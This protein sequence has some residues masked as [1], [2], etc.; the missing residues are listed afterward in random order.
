MSWS[1]K[2]PT[3]LGRY[4]VTHNGVVRQADLA[5][6]PK[7]KL[8]WVILPSG[9]APLS[10]GSVTAWQREPKPFNEY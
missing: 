2:P 8:Y 1:T 6:Y 10:G 9:T 5:E 7:G 3:K 4:L